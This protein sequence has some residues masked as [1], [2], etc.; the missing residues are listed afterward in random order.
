MKVDKPWG[1]FR[2][3]S[4]NKNCSVKIITLEPHQETSLHWHNLRS[5][6]W[7][8][9]DAGVKVQIGEEIH[10]AVIG[11]EF[12]IPSGTVHKLISQSDTPARILEIAFGYTNEEDVHRLADQYG[13]EL[14]L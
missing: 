13:R 2:Q 5:D 1:F 9:L 12:Y 10:E 4:Y 11:E 8:V 3:Y 14:T 7:V 6:S